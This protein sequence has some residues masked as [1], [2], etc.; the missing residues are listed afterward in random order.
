MANIEAQR[1][2][3]LAAAHWRAAKMGQAE[4]LYENELRI[5][6]WLSKYANG[7]LRTTE[8]LLLCLQNLGSCKLLC[9]DYAGAGRCF[10]EAFSR[11]RGRPRPLTRRDVAFTAQMLCLAAELACASGE[12]SR[13]RVL[14]VEATDCICG[15]LGAGEEARLLPYAS[16]L[17]SILLQHG[18]DELA[19]SLYTA[20]M[21][22]AMKLLVDRSGDLQWHRRICRMAGDASSALDGCGRSHEARASS[23][24]ELSLA[25]SCV[26]LSG[27]AEEDRRNL[28]EAITW[29][30][31]LAEEAGDTALALD[32]EDA[33]ARQQ[34]PRTA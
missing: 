14:A 29:A 9:G 11:I 27:G 26:R 19:A 15:L 1:L 31:E 2:C 23:R 3:H 21:P 25:L 6:R 7:S 30:A 8:P 28:V 5:R 16:R 10:A 34:T 32:L 4:L 17:G 13:G 12:L 24:E 20:L 22:T 18:F 33:A